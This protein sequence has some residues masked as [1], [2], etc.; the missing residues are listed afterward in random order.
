VHKENSNAL[1]LFLAFPKTLVFSNDRRLMICGQ[2]LSK[3]E[4]REQPK[5]SKVRLE[6]RETNEISNK[7]T[8]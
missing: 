7:T 3:R 5:N 6:L 4:R 8:K 1:Y 2:C